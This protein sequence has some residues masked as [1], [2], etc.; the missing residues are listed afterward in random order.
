MQA[1]IKAI[2]T[3]TVNSH[4]DLYYVTSNFRFSYS[5]TK[6]YKVMPNYDSALLENKKQFLEKTDW[7]LSTYLGEDMTDLE[8][9]LALHDYLVLN[10]AYDWNVA[11]GYSSGY[12]QTVFS[13]YGALVEENA[14]CQGYALAY[15]YLLSRV[16]ISAGLITLSL[17]H[18]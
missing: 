9:A 11:N 1:K 15:Q 13:P 17:I 4:A 16:G 6:V 18:I 14:V 8:K 10:C 12:S 7:I 5:S 3:E 2:Y